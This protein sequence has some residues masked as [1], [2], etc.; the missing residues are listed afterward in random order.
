MSDRAGDPLVYRRLSRNNRAKRTSKGDEPDELLLHQR[1]QLYSEFCLN[2]EPVIRLSPDG[3]LVYLFFDEDLRFHV[4]DLVRN[5]QIVFKVDRPAPLDVPD[6]AVVGPTAILALETYALWLLRL[7]VE[8]G[9]FE[10]IELERR[11]DYSA[12]YVFT[13]ICGTHVELKRTVLEQYYSSEYRFVR[14][15]VD[16]A[17]LE[18]DAVE[19]L[20]VDLDLHL[21]ADGRW[22]YGL[23]IY[24]S[25]LNTLHVFDIE[26]QKWSTKKLTGEIGRVHA[27]TF[28]W[29]EDCVFVLGYYEMNETCSYSVFRLDLRQFA[30]TKLHR[31][32]NTIR[33]RR[34]SAIVE[35]GSGEA[36]GLLL[37]NRDEGTWRMEV[38]RLLFRTPDS[39]VR[40]AVDALR[41]H[42]LDVAGKE[43]FYNVMNGPCK[44]VFPSVYAGMTPIPRL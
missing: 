36:G 11:P 10:A 3:R 15:D 24:H 26:R 1:L 12:T 13:E 2:A 29:T 21:T 34:I 27:W 40:L 22:L 14:L 4:V 42:N 16:E 39:L 37:L 35:P 41:R 17:R 43:E 38:F 8:S 18:V 28:A 20:T 9:T 25:R 5:A 23:T 30:W 7:D 31:V 19:Q 32:C 44:G 33:L 6:F